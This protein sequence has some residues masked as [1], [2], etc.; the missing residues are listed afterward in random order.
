MKASISRREFLK[1]F[2]LYSAG[3]VAPPVL[4]EK[5]ADALPSTSGISGRLANDLEKQNVLVIVFDAWSAQNVSLYGYPRKT[6]PRLERLA[7]KAVV[8]HNHYASGNYTS[9]G[10]ASLLSGVLPWTHRSL[11]YDNTMADDFLQKN[12]FHAFSSYHR[13]AYSHNSLVVTLLNQCH[14]NVDHL[15]PLEQLL[16]SSDGFIPRLFQNDSDTASIGWARAIKRHEEG[17]AYSL[18]L[19]SLYEAY[20]ENQVKRYRE[21]FPLGL[22][23]I[24]VDNYYRLEDAIAWLENTLPASPQP[25][26]GY[27]HFLPPHAPY[28]T[29]REYYGK[30]ARDKYK[31]TPKPNHKF[32]ESKPAAKLLTLRQKYDEY[33][34]YIDDQFARL[35]EFME[36]SGLLEN[37]WLVLT[38][39]HGEIFERGISHH[40]TSVLCQPLVHVPLVVFEPGRQ[41]R[42]DVTSPTNAIDLLPTLLHVTHHSPPEWSEGEILPPY[43]A[44]PYDP[45]R[46]IISMQP[47]FNPQ[48]S[49]LSKGTIMLRKGDH[50]LVY[51]FGYDGLRQGEEYIELFDLANDPEEMHNLYPAEK[52]IGSALLDEVQARLEEANRKYL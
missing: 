32:T 17:Y 37:T 23:H 46:S 21:D 49:P 9:P 1:I 11:N 48:F 24:N 25:F 42:L 14:Q 30:F 7:E 39:D 47:R 52:A 36:G 43:R 51:F 29:R 28:Y 19:S 6:M 15:L 41:Q 3:M 44:T 13:M 31:P 33:L 45:Q 16:L 50:K 4:W 22:P 2:G 27:F 35:Y 20:K 12:I 8:Y 26:M 18:F 10:T 34:L 38:T 5:A 40:T